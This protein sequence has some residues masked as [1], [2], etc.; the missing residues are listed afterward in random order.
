MTEHPFCTPEFWRNRIKENKGNLQDAVQ[1]VSSWEKTLIGHKKILDKFV[2][3][4]VFDAGCGYGRVIEYLPETITD[5]VGMDITPE[6]I[7]EAKKR[8]PHRRFL[9]GDIRK[10]T[11]KNKEFD[12]AI[13]IGMANDN[14]PWYEMEK[15]LIRVAKNV[16]LLWLSKP[17]A[18][19][20]FKDEGTTEEKS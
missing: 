15:E 5:Y 3:G 6:F 14:R 7:E 13:A 1:S 8:Y 10:T 19:F 16:L 2:K 20:I 11:F 4:R 9:L 12:W 17:D 18:Y